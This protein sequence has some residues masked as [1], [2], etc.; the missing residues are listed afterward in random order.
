MLD[1]RQFGIVFYFFQQ[2]EKQDKGAIAS[3]E[4]R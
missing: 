4:I 2:F 1:E 3:W